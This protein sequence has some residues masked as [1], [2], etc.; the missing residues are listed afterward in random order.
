MPRIEVTF[1]SGRHERCAAW[2]YLPE[3]GPSGCVVMAH[4]FA[5]TR[6]DGIEP[7]AERFAAAGLAVVLF[8]YRHFGDSEGEPRQLLEFRRQLEDYRAAIDYARSREEVD[9]ARIAVWGTS[10][11]GAHAIELAAHDPSLAAAVAQTPMVDGRLQV[12]RFP[13]P[14]LYKA[15]GRAIRDQIAA[16][17]RRPPV[18]MPVRGRPQDVAAL[19]SPSSYEGYGR[20]V[21]EESKWR[22]DVAARVLLQVGLYRPLT[23]AERVTCPL[24]VCAGDRDDLTPPE[25]AVRCAERAPRGELRRYDAD[26]W[27]VYPGGDAFEDVVSDQVEFLTRHLGEGGG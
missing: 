24:L 17:R 27:S 3:N 25:P 7:F 8:D 6:R 16:V 14:A 9:A 22:D 5:G 26:H 12:L 18:T 1:P 4:G 21:T 19:T 2:L 15:T 20:L 11:S 13:R 10:F 23:G